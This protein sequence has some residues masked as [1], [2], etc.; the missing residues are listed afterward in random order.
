ADK[1]SAPADAAEGLSAADIFATLSGETAEADHA[2][3]LEF[4]VDGQD[5][6]ESEPGAEASARLISALN[7]LSKE[8]VGSV[9]TKRREAVPENEFHVPPVGEVSIEDLM[10]PLQDEARF[11]REVKELK[12]L[13]Q[14]EGLPEPASEAARSREER[15]IQYRKTSKDVE[16]WFPQVHRMNR[17]EQVVLDSEPAVLQSTTEIV[18]A[19][20]GHCPSAYDGELEALLHAQAIG[21]SA[22]TSECHFGSD[23]QSALAAA[24]G[25][26]SFKA[27]SQL[28]AAAIGLA[29]TLTAQG[30]QLLL[31]KIEAHSGCAFNSLADEIAKH[32]GTTGQSLPDSADWSSLQAAVTE[33]VLE[34]AWL[35]TPDSI[36]AA[37]LPPLQ[38]D[39]TWSKP[40]AEVRSSAPNLLPP[41]LCKVTGEVQT[42]ALDLRLLT[43]NAL[44]VRGAT[45]RALICTGLRKHRIDLAGLQ[46]T[47]DRADG[48]SS[49]EEFWVLAAPCDKGGHFGVQL[50]LR[51][52]A[53]WDRTSF[54]IVHADPRVLI[55]VCTIRGVKLVLVCAHAPTSVTGDEAIGSWWSHLTRLLAKVPKVCAPLLFIDANARFEPHSSHRHTLDAAPSNFNATCLRQFA[56][57]MGLHLSAQQDEQGR[58]LHSWRS[59]KGTTSLIDYVG[60]PIDW[61]NGHSTIGNVDLADLHADWDHLPIHTRLRAHIET[62][63]PSSRTKI[64]PKDLQ[65]E[66]GQIRAIHAVTSAPLVP[67]TDTCTTHVETLQS[68]MIR[69]MQDVQHTAQPAARNP[70]I[71]QATLGL[72]RL[73]RHMRRCLRTVNRR[74]DMGFLHLCLQA[75]KHGTHPPQ[76]FYKEAKTA[77]LNMARSYHGLAVVDKQLRQAMM[78][79]RAQFAR[80]AR[81]QIE[82]SRQAGPAEFAHRMRA[83]LRT[84]RKFRPPPLLPALTKEPEAPCLA[85]D[86]KD[87]FAKHFAIAERAVETEVQGLNTEVSVACP[88]NRHDGTAVPSIAALT[89]GFASLK[90]SK[91]AGLSGLPSEAFLG[92][93]LTAALRYWPA[94][95]KELLR[96]RTAIH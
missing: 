35:A 39:G 51:K 41:Y 64:A 62:T 22:S 36:F 96:D 84:G 81:R 75:W 49:C 42:V 10:A 27:G 79:D 77:R 13:S 83:I 68:S 66:E 45:A 57:D 15:S 1:T 52:A 95:A 87:T 25:F 53:G 7:A 90:R 73:R 56:V 82:Q 71:S 23:C 38:G 14:R 31:H 72:I 44:S 20:A 48:I 69:S 3:T 32:A 50:W 55:V 59:P 89:N 85:D 88:G 47:R 60:C 78:N 86:V 93:P 24:F 29:A 30:K 61:K 76:E 40:N 65:T 92:A 26:C 6:D 58:P 91:A 54:A 80:V 9:E 21:I 67:W 46:E 18:G 5:D 4:D 17:A 8:P 2:E 37:T 28:P 16:K 19:T 12:A 94:I 74:S 34:R 33:A 43:Y 11:T 70:A 63:V